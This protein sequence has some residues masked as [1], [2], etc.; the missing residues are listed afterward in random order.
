MH[1]VFKRTSNPHSWTAHLHSS[2][3]WR[4]DRYGGNGNTFLKIIFILQRHV[5]SYN[6]SIFKPDF[7]C[8]VMYQCIFLK[9]LIRGDHLPRTFTSFP[10]VLPLYSS[11]ADPHRFTSM[12]VH[13]SIVWVH[14]F[15]S[16]CIGQ[17]PK[18]KLAINCVCLGSRSD[19]TLVRLEFLRNSMSVKSR[20]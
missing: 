5:N 1:S 6:K 9:S 20:K 16:K 19:P 7:H 3:M 12:H 17:I 4:K 14:R 11:G 15:I 8:S 10:V 2:H 18:S 13:R